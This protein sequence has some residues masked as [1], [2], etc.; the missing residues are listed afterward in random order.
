[1]SRLSDLDYSVMVSFSS[2]YLTVTGSE[3]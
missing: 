1:M 2:I 3:N